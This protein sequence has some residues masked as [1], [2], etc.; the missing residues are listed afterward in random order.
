MDFMAAGKL[1]KPGQGTL[2]KEE[3]MVLEQGER[4]F[5]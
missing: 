3:R 4:S 1:R 2:G 5:I